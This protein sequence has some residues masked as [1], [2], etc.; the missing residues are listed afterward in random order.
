MEKQLKVLMIEDDSEIVESVAVMF[1]LRWPEVNLLSTMYGEKGVELAESE[2]P[3]IVILDIGLPDMDGFQVLRRIR[4]FSDVPVVI[5]T[6]MGEEIN[7]IRG[8]ELGADDY[9]VKPFSPGE[10]LARVRAV[11]R[12][13]HMPETTDGAGGKPFIRGKLR[14]DFASQ[15]VSV[16]NK[17]LKIGPRDY[18]LLCQLVANEG[19]V[20]SNEV[21]LETISE[22]G[23]TLSMEFLRVLMNR[24]KEKVETE[25][26]NQNMIINEGGKGYKLVTH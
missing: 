3:D 14:I 4:T 8:L 13:L 20:L 17:L 9:V 11:I 10:F 25:T 19:E 6:V 2:S 15:E 24:L 21:L 23:S 7:K 18:E 1:Q 5:L 16:G 22:T 26:G 12:R